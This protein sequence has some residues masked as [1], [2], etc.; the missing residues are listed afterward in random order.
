YR[1]ARDIYAQYVEAF[2]SSEDPEFVADSAF[3]IRFF[4]AEILWALEEW[5]KAAEAYDAVVAFKVPQ[6]DSA[7]E[8]SNESY[9]EKAAYAAVL[10]YDKLVKIERGELARSNLKDGEKVNE[11]KDK[12][13]MD[14]QGRLVKRDA[15]DVQEKP[16]SRF[17]GKLV[18]ACD[19]YNR[20]YP[21]N[22][23]EIDLRYQAAVVL[24][25]RNHF[26]EAARRFGEIIEKFPE[27]KRSQDAADLT[28]YVLETRQEWGELNALSR[29]FLANKKLTRSNADFARRVASVV[30]GS[31]Y[32]WVHEQVYLKEK[33][34]AKAADEF[35]KFVA[36]F[37][38]SENA[39]R[40][41]TSAMVI[42]Q[43][44]NQ[45]DRGVH[46][47]EQLL[48]EHP[49]SPYALQARYTLAQFYEKTAEFKKS[50]AMYE[51]FVAAYDAAAKDKPEV[52]KNPGDDAAAKKRAEAAAVRRAELAKAEKWV[53]DAL[54]NA[55]LWWEG[56]G[57]SGKAISAYGSYLSRFRDRKDVPDIAYN[58]AL[59]HEKDKKW[60]EA[61][62]AFERFADTY[63]RDS[64][65]TPG[66]VY[67]ARY[68]RMLALRE[69]RNA[70]EAERAQAELVR[71]WSRLSAEARKDVSV[72]DA[73]AHARFLQVEPQWK[74]YT[75]RKLNRVNTLKA[76]LL[77]KQRDLQRLEKAYID[78]LNTGA[79]EWA[80]ASLTRI[81]LAY[82]DFARNILESPDPKGLDEEQRELYRAELENLAMPLEEKAAEAL[83][84]GLA[85]AY[86]LALYNEWTLAAQEQV[87]K[88]QPG[89]Y[90]RVREVPYRGS[91]F[92]ATAG[93]EKEPGQPATGSAKAAPEPA[94]PVTAPAAPVAPSTQP[95]QPAP[96]PTARLEE[97]R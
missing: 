29:K 69:A 9:R 94:A 52:K 8:A 33:N 32:K 96:A 71:G 21:G 4:Y 55:G 89:R 56:V 19:T 57:E 44:A 1:L 49:R 50:A 24:Y 17:E 51:A 74:G 78:V 35:L 15:S 76:D 13:D 45:L 81:G 11:R 72:L 6:R 73:Y 40:A 28:M 18:A 30:E 14:K 80:I 27:E 22:K 54:F 5:D 68:R 47:G 48:R 70:P 91:E 42:F 62:R 61:A 39:D 63:A 34:P 67:V 31:Q 2:A 58:I 59:V 46:A 26:V 90:A 92:F 66:K 25:D 43:E 65:T 7:K 3:N 82:A 64:R 95:E 53:A 83:D 93:V 84:K 10:A 37:P 87:N 41:L 36:E 20:L 85:K 77:A 60:G 79:G 75:E 12:G 23:D 88:Y 86:E 16:L 38:R 97:A